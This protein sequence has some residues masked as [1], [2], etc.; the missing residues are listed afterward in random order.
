M[1]VRLYAP[2]EPALKMK[3]DLL[4]GDTITGQASWRKQPAMAGLHVPLP[5][6]WL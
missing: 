2:K 5:G 1:Q 3:A 4:C 6:R